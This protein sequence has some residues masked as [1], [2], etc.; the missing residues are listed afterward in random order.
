VIWQHRPK[1][2]TSQDSVTMSS[3]LD[4][5]CVFVRVTQRKIWLHDFA[6]DCRIKC[7]NLRTVSD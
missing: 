3:Y 4:I 7:Q 2:S 1:A 6:V 5:L